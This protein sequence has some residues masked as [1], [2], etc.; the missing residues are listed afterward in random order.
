[1]NFQKSTL[2]RALRYLSTD[3]SVIKCAAQDN[4]P[5]QY[6]DRQT[7]IA[8]ESAV[9]TTTVKHFIWWVRGQ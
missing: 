6:G 4:S 3:L 7:N 8:Y 1:M 2:F 5:K 9:V